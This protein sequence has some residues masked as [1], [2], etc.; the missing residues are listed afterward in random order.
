MK[1]QG[2]SVL[3]NL[4]IAILL[5]AIMVGGTPPMALAKIIDNVPEIP[6]GP[7]R[8]CVK[9]FIGCCSSLIGWLPDGPIEMGAYVLVSYDGIGDSSVTHSC[10]GGP[11]FPGALPEGN[12]FF[13]GGGGQVGLVNIERIGGDCPYMLTYYGLIN[14]KAISGTAGT[15]VKGIPPEEE[16]NEGPP[17][18]QG[19][20]CQ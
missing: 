20:C 16:N 6:V 4:R 15:C 12:F 2:D 1:F 7:G 9:Y 11:A 8:V 18:E 13:A 17:C 19:L 3:Q 5:L 14:Q 10:A